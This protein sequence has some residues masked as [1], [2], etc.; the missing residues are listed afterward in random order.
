M[1]RSGNILYPLLAA[2][3]VAALVWSMQ[4]PLAAMSIAE[5]APASVRAM[6]FGVTAL[7]PVYLLMR[8]HP[9]LGDT[10]AWSLAVPPAGALFLL[11]G[12]ILALRC[13]AP[14]AVLAWAAMASFGAIVMMVGTSL[15]RPVFAALAMVPAHGLCLTALLLLSGRVSSAA[16][17]RITCAIYFGVHT[18]CGRM[19]W[20]TSP[21]AAHIFGPTA[22]M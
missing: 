4:L 12:C 11:A 7:L 19:P 10:P 8:V 6:V 15:N 18:G 13:R 3:L 5:T 16:A 14:G 22:A 1:H 17:G 21:A 20:A 9:F 2:V